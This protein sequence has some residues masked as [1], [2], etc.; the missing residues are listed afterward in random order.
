MHYIFVLLIIVVGLGMLMKEADRLVENSVATTTRKAYGV[1]IDKLYSF[2]DKYGIEV[3]YS[4]HKTTIE[5]FIV[6]LYRKGLSHGSL[7]STLSAIR[8]YCRSKNYDCVF[9]TERL[10]LLLK[11]ARRLQV[12]RHRC[13]NGLSLYDLQSLMKASDHLDKSMQCWVKA[14]FSLAF[15]GFLRP[16]E[17]AKAQATPQ[18]QLKRRDIKFTTHALYVSFSSF[19]HSVGKPVVVRIDRQMGSFVCPWKNM[20]NYIASCSLGDDDLLFP[21]TVGYV[22]KVLHRCRVIS[23]KAEKVTL[24]S[25][26]RGGATWASQ[27]GWSNSKLQTHGRWRSNAYISY[28]KSA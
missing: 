27:Q 21:Y 7:V 28:V 8:H 1:V 6:S 4:F 15:F 3:K 16:C 14:L 19:K 18:H 23:G 5:L 10:R 24:H 25:F 12:V 26:R 17:M 9:D 13:T 11:G 2:C 22:Q 20:W